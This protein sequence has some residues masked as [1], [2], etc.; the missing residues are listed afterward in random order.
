MSKL[1]SII[2]TLTSIINLSLL[3]LGVGL[4]QNCGT[5]SN[6]SSDRDQDPAVTG[7]TAQT[8]AAAVAGDQGGEVGKPKMAVC[9]TDDEDDENDENDEDDED[10]ENET[11]DTEEGEDDDDGDECD[12]DVVQPLQKAQV[13]K[14]LGVVS[15][16]MIQ[17]ILQESCVACH[18]GT[19]AEDGYNLEG[20]SN[21]KAAID[22]IIES[23]EEGEMP[24]S[25]MTA[26]S[27]E[28]LSLLATWLETGLSE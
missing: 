28:D 7:Q 11:E 6:G 10:D 24:P 5:G 13:D 26:I 4:L 22:D 23:I 25:G 19:R 14:S 8:K 1:S 20:Y 3:F 21:A 15:Y 17:G 18:N 27:K 12:D 9:P 2:K 16:G